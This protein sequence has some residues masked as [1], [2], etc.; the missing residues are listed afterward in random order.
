MHNRSFH[1]NWLFLGSACQILDRALTILSGG[2]DNRLDQRTNVTVKDFRAN[3]GFRLK[4]AGKTMGLV[5]NIARDGA[6]E[7]FI[8]AQALYL[9][10]STVFRIS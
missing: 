1:P 4:L 8:Q 7:S 10:D 3:Q 5:G 9:D 2:V 6:R